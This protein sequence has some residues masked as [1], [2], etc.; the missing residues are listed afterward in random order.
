[1]GDKS[2]KANQKKK[3]QIDAKSAANNK[4]KQQ[5]ILDKQAPGKKR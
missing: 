2:P 3:A 1:M 5:A 4:R